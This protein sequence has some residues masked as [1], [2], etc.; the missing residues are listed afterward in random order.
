MRPAEAV[1]SVT[2]K[3]GK[4]ERLGGRLKYYYRQAAGLTSGDSLSI[5]ANARRDSHCFDF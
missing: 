2:G 4:K 3:I 5:P 1:G